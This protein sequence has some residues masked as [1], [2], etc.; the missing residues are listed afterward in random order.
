MSYWLNRSVEAVPVARLTLW[1][2]LEVEAKRPG[3]HP[4]R[5]PWKRAKLL[6]AL[7]AASDHATA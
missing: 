2:A 6:G 7:C 5:P 3:R 1:R 4:K